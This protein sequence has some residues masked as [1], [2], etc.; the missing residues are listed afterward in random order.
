MK[1]YN[2]LNDW[3]KIVAIATILCFI[4]WVLAKIPIVWDFIPFGI[5]YEAGG[6]ILSALITIVCSLYFLVKWILNRFSLRM[7]YLYGFLLGVFTLLIMRLVYSIDL[8]GII[9]MT[10]KI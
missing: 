10:N 5:L 2:R 9:W 7:I 3:D 4:F 6:W 8:N 1:A